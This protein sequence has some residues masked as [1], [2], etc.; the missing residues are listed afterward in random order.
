MLIEFTDASLEYLVGRVSYSFINASAA[1][2]ARLP[3][4]VLKKC[5]LE[6]IEAF[7]VGVFINELEKLGSWDA[8]GI[9]KEDD[10]NEW[11]EI[12]E[13]SGHEKEACNGLGMVEVTKRGI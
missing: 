13:P 7:K 8:I 1:E 9:A 11:V 5:E 6:A 10:P 4:K 12:A 2:L 3:P